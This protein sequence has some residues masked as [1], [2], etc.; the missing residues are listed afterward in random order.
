MGSLPDSQQRGAGVPTHQQVQEWAEKYGRAWVDADS[1]AVAAL[2]TETATYR[3]NIYEEPHQGRAGISGY[4]S[5]ATS[6]QSD[7]DVRMGIPTVDGAKATVEFWTTMAIAGNPV[8]LAGCLLL[9][10]DDSGLCSAL[11]EYWNF[12]DG[13]NHPPEGW[14]V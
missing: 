9:D 5:D 13:T 14:G 4:W 12:V 10:F 2:F 1:D 7:V 6:A 3:A 11:R 8:T